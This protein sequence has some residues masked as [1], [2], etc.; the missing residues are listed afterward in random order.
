MP[1]T[2]FGLSLSKPSLGPFDRLRPFDKLTMLG[3]FD[4]LRPF[5]KL[6]MLGPFDKLRANG[7]G[8]EDVSYAR[9]HQSTFGTN[10]H[11]LY[12]RAAGSSTP[13]R[14]VASRRIGASWLWL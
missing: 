3:P 14:S 9:L 8:C 1:P 4:K 13:S 12:W 2:P 7:G 11:S 5:D 6:T 10:F